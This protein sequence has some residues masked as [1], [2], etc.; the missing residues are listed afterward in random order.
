MIVDDGLSVVFR[1]ELFEDFV[2]LGE[3]GY[4]DDDECGWEWVC[5]DEGDDLDGFAQTHFVG[6]E[7]TMRFGV[8]PPSDDFWGH[9]AGA[10]L[11][12]QTPVHTL[13]LMF[14]VIKL[15]TCHQV[16]VA[17]CRLHCLKLIW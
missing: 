13:C 1:L 11:L 7:A 16:S 4:W 3:E 5:V 2:P 12:P 8:S 14:L 10:L 9:P 6:N 15:V 17:G